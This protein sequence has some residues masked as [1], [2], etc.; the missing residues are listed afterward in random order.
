MTR[1][2]KENVY[3]FKA[4][5]LHPRDEIGAVGKAFFLLLLPYIC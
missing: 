5:A 2:K 4:A 1:A 3:I